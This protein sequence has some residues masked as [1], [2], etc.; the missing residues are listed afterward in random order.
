[1][2]MYVNVMPRGIYNDV[3][4]LPVGGG[5][6]VHDGMMVHDHLMHYKRYRIHSGAVRG[7]LP[8]RK[9]C[10]KNRGQMSYMQDH[11][12]ILVENIFAL[13]V[14]NKNNLICLGRHFL[15]V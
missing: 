3:L 15:L 13:N 11:P 10:A 8:V 6:R 2:A 12:F 7:F 1:M 14:L 4:V 9:L 5:T